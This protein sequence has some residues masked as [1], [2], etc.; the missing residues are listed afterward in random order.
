MSQRPKKPT[1][2]VTVAG[3][4]SAANSQASGAATSSGYTVTVTKPDELKRHE[5]SDEELTVLISDGRSFRR[6]VFWAGLGA[7]IGA[8][9]PA[10]SAL[11][12]L[13]SQDRLFGWWELGEVLVCFGGLVVVV[14][15]IIIGWRTPSPAETLTSEIRERAAS[16]VETAQ[17]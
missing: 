6:D 4:S 16:K 13:S 15:L 5:I 8:F 3:G 7:F 17:S 11:R 14:I 12:A 10:L 9:A 1:K 2:T